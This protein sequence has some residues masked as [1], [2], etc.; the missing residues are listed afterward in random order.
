[1]DKFESNWIPGVI[2]TVLIFS[3]SLYLFWPG[4]SEAIQKVSNFERE[5]R[6]HLDHSVFFGEYSSGFSKPQEV[7]KACL[8][9]HADAAENVMKTPHWTWSR[10]N[11]VLS[12]GGKKMEIGKKNLINN[13]CINIKGNW[14]A[15]TK[16]HTGYGWEDASFDFQKEENVDCLI[17]HDWTG[18]YTKSKAGYPSK[19]VDLLAVARGV[20]YPKRDNCGMCHFS[21]GGGMGVKHGDLDDSLIYAMDS[22]DVHMGKHDLLCIDCHKTEN[23]LIPGTAF[24]VSTETTKK[25]DCLD[26]HESDVHENE[27]INSHTKSIACQTCHIP[28]YAKRSPTKMTWDWSKAG[29]PNRKN[30]PHEYLKIK[31]EFT[32]DSNVRPEYYWFNRTVNRYILGDKIDPTKVNDMNYPLGDIN[33]KEAKI[34]PFKV[35]RAIQPYDKQHLYFVPVVTAGEGGYWK[36]FNWDKAI[37]KGTEL[38][39]MEYSGQYGFAKSQMFWP[40]SHM[41]SPTKESLGCV[42]CHGDNSIMDWKALGYERDPAIIGGR[43]LE[44]K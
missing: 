4:G 8:K 19:D 3:I 23:H 21:G 29:D 13:F 30:D 20:G 2:L 15:C 38:F 37:R 26:C 32:Y 41:V 27:R 24:S 17:C 5:R 12:R 22:V 43:K 25:V 9:C 31:G 28:K 14:P 39:G 36:E 6:V 44:D 34:W 16:C 40:L 35:H 33:D 11:T 10:T 18:T 1:M 42:D 7:T